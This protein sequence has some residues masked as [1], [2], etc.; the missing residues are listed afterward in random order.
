MDRQQTLD[1]AGTEIKSRPSYGPAKDN[2]ADIATMWSVILGVPVT[3]DQVA[4]MMIALKLCREKNGHKADNFVDI[5]GF[6][7]IGN[8][9]TE[10]LSNVA[11]K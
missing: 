6:A 9:I 5:A 10:E 11:V 1:Q 7:A 3:V 8:E 4:P 2:F